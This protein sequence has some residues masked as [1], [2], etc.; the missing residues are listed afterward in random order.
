VIYLRIGTTVIVTSVRSVR[1]WRGKVTDRE[2][3]PEGLYVAVQPLETGRG[4]ST[5]PVPV[6]A[7]LCEPLLRVADEGAN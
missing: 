4:W 7:E 5:Q 6:R 3:R 2:Q 1:S